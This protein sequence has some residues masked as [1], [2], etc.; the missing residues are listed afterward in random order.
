MAVQG[1][2]GVPPWSR[3]LLSH[4]RAPGLLPA[5][6]RTRGGCCYYDD[7]DD[8]DDVDAV[9]SCHVMIAP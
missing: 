6:E 7:D 4:D 3:V 8:D 5:P 9:M 1:E 2:V